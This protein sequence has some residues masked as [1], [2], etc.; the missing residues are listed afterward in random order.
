MSSKV[1]SSR[2]TAPRTARVMTHATT[3]YD[4]LD[5]DNASILVAGGGGV[6]LQVT[7][8]LKDMGSWVWL[9][10]RT[11]VR[12][13][14]IEKMMAIVPR[15]D[16]LVPADLQ[17]VFDGIEEVDAVISCLGGTTADPRADGEGNINLIEAALKKGV[18]KFVLVTSIGCGSTKDACG[19]QVYNVLKPVLVEKDRAEAVLMAA[20]DKM[21]FVIIRPG[22]LSNDPATGKA[23]LTEDNTVCGSI[24]RA[25][26]A[27]LVCQAVFSTKSDNKILS[28]LDNTKIYGP[29][30]AEELKM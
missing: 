26:V 24:A 27:T 20:K 4:S 5:P 8:K 13:A 1:S 15:G 3:S 21:T 12:K 10:Q 16:A 6:A 7:R 23:V 22:G 29:K 2:A 25:D 17:K 9:M 30:Q 19:E 11:D 18:K 14:E 28:A